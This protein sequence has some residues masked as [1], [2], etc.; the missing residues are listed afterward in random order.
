M[1]A[2][3]LALLQLLILWKIKTKEINLHF[4]ISDDT[5]AASLSRFQFL[6]FTF[7][8][9]V[10]FL[11]LTMKGSGFPT[12]DDGVLMLLGISGATFALSKGL[13][14]QGAVAGKDGKAQE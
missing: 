10:G 9:A 1:I 6:I 5:G 4:L 11:Y 3:F 13:D 2:A 7:V 14:R 12:V 8:I